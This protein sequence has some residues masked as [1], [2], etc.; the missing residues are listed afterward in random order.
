[1][2]IMK[3]IIFLILFVLFFTGNVNAQKWT[4]FNDQ[5]SLPSNYIQSVAVGPDNAIWIGTSKGLCRFDG[6][7]WTYY[8][9]ITALAIEFSKDGNMWIANG[10]GLVK[11][12]GTIWTTYKSGSD[13]ENGPIYENV[14]DVKVAKDNSVWVAS[15]HKVSG[16]FY[17]A[18]SHFDGK[19]W[20]HYTTYGENK[21]LK[22]FSYN[23][24]AIGPDDK[25]WVINS[26]ETVD[27]IMSFDGINWV[28]YKLDSPVSIAVTDNNDIYVGA[29]DGVYKF[30]NDKFIKISPEHSLFSD[31]SMDTV[32]CLKA[33]SGNSLLASFDNTYIG[34]YDGIKWTFYTFEDSMK[35]SSFVFDLTI[36]SLGVLWIGYDGIGVARLNPSY[37]SVEDESPVQ[38]NIKII[39]NYPNP[40]NS[41]T[42]IKYYLPERGNA[43]LMVYDLMGRKVISLISGYIEAGYHNVKW[44]GKDEGGLNTASGIYIIRLQ[45]NGYSTNKKV[46]F[47]K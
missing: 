25:I 15:A 43:E 37:T 29:Y 5:N 32:F 20:K 12:D 45:Q 27:E 38:Y 30:Y 35:I 40:F 46:E 39:G 31:L 8:N 36:D 2:I 47:L 10:D 6:Y 7:I 17:S 24:L 11:Y 16:I 1:M 28:E 26:D 14:I 42:E 22:G 23:P 34:I 44:D 41:S 3:K 19:T 4:I 21:I 9:G 13:I 33:I 18:L